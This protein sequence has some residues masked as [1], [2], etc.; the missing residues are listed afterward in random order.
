MC[1]IMLNP[2]TADAEKDDNT[3]R[4][5]RHFAKREG[6]TH[7]IVVNLFAYRETSRKKLWEAA[8][9][10]TDIIGPEN[11]EYIIHAV[12]ECF[13]KPVLA[14]WSSDTKAVDRGKIVKKMVGSIADL[15]CLGM[16]KEGHPRH[17]LYLENDQPIEEF[18]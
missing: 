12:K 10:G 13:N 7:L 17:P 5:C 15:Y 8:K 11:D 9:E 4:R 3:I 18:L 1:I 14:A 2:S 16:T 6:A